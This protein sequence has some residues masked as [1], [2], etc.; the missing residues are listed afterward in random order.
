[1]DRDAGCG[2]PSDGSLAADRSGPL[3]ST[4][5]PCPARISSP[6]TVFAATTIMVVV[7]VVVGRLPRPFPLVKDR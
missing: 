1:M 4:L 7:V 2:S 6:P 5:F 3:G